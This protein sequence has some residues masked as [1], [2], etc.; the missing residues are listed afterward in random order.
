MVT[1]VSPSKNPEPTT[2]RVGPPVAATSTGHD[3]DATASIEVTVGTLRYFKICVPDVPVGLVT[4]M[5]AL[6][7]D[8]QAE[9]MNDTVLFVVLEGATST[10]EAPAHVTATDETVDI[11]L[12]DTVTDPPDSGT[13]V[14]RIVSMLGA[15]L[16]PG[17]TDCVAIERTLV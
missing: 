13:P 5:V 4:A 9:A 8:V 14:G 1:V 6:P 10:A 11:E 15:A 17:V 16:A 12:P 7:A 2:V 3:S